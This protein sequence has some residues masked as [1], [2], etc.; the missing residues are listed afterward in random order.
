MLFSKF[1]R[2]GSPIEII[3]LLGAVTAPLLLTAMS[4]N[5]IFVN[6]NINA[7]AQAG[8]ESRPNYFIRINP[9]ATVE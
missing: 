1:L 9:G 8:Q 3:L 4:T 6:G 7:Y 5:S 2:V